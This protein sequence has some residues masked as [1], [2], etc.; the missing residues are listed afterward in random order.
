MAA[1][2]CELGERGSACY[3]SFM[4]IIQRIIRRSGVATLTLLGLS[5]GVLAQSSTAAAPKLNADTFKLAPHY[6]LGKFDTDKDSGKA[7]DFSLPNKVNLGGSQLQF[8]TSRKDNMPHG[9]L[10][11]SDTSPL[12]AGSPSRND[13]QIPPAYFGLTLT[14][15]TR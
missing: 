12:M 13:S 3:K 6:D 7:E 8:D 15:P 1:D 5:H 11:N 9:G 14:K 2:T 4:N 10:D